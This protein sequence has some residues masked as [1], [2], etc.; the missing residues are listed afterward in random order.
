MFSST[1]NTSITSFHK[2]VRSQVIPA[3]PRLLQPS[4]TND[5]RRKELARLISAQLGTTYSGT[6]LEE[7]Y[8]CLNRHE[9]SKI[10]RLIATANNRY[11]PPQPSSWREEEAREGLNSLLAWYQGE[12]LR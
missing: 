7:R 3:P 11:T 10:D 9:R 12:P 1:F 8:A 2:F 4:L 6:K 5:N